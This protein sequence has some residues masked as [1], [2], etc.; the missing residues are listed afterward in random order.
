MSGTNQF[1]I[2]RDA[3]LTIQGSSGPLTFNI[4]T[5]FDSKP[6][7][8]KLQSRGLD[9]TKRTRNL[10]DGHSGSFKID[11][12]D[13]TAEDYFLEQ[14]ANFFAG[15]NPDTVTITQTISEANGSVSQYQFTGVTL[16]LEDAGSWAGLEKVNQVINFDATRKIKVS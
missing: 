12:A 4:I 16:S 8:Q 1:N 2:G 13:S 14:E 5:G 15:L 6:Q 3:Q 9:G 11:R 10:P 7:Y